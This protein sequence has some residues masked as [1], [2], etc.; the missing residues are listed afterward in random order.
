[1][2]LKS[3][4]AIALAGIVS[5][6]QADDSNN[7][8]I[9]IEF[10]ANIKNNIQSTGYVK[11]T[12]APINFGFGISKEID[13]FHIGLSSYHNNIRA[14]GIKKDTLYT[15]DFNTHAF[16]LQL[17]YDC[18]AH[19]KVIP[20]VTAGVGMSRN[21]TDAYIGLGKNTGIYTGN[22][23]VSPAYNI[24]AGMKFNLDDA[25]QVMIGYKYYN[26]GTAKTS[27]NILVNNT[28]V[29]GDMIKSKLKH[30]NIFVALLLKF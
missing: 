21:K 23:T 5:I 2:Y 29:S 13:N 27:S 18:P 14:R 28:T 22:N 3:L 19:P 24:G 7:Y 15:Q 12:N 26:L 25:H 20:F 16:F 9:K 8:H 17:D 1:M 11:R 30:H 4:L 10:G 6:A